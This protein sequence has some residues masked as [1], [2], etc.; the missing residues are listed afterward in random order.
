MKWKG[1]Q[2]YEM[3][4]RVAIKTLEEIAHKFEFSTEDR[5]PLIQTC[6]TTLSSKIV[7]RCKR[8]MAEM[9]VEAVLSVADLERRDVNLDLI[10]LDGKVGAK[11]DDTRLVHGIVLDKD[12]SHPQMPKELKDVKVCPTVAVQ[13]TH[14][15]RRC[16]CYL[17]CT[18]AV[19]AVSTRHA[20]VHIM[21]A[22]H[23]A[24]WYITLP[25][26]E[27]KLHADCYLDMCI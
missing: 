5:E 3:A 20:A 16:T 22:L 4:C 6:M 14:H 21:N 19:H 15:M 27:Y 12:F 11:T 24:V 10:K 26:S 18:R 8:E 23:H 13:N 9:C 7:G 1:V 25:C 17:A 2:G